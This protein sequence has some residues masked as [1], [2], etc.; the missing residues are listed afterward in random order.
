MIKGKDQK[1]Y[2]TKAEMLAANPVEEKVEEKTEPDNLK[3]F[4]K[5]MKDIETILKL[6][7]KGCTP[8]QIATKVWIAKAY[9]EEV[10]SK[11]YE[12]MESELRLQYHL[13]AEKK[14]DSVNTD[15]GEVPAPDEAEKAKK[16]KREVAAKGESREDAIVK[17][18]QDNPEGLTKEG[19]G[20]AVNKLLNINRHAW[21][22]TIGDVKKSGKITYDKEKKLYYAA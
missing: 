4:Q 13:P 14:V 15:A 7:E 3:P 2:K 9:V 8:D 19:I 12:Q 16:P 6:K 22:H 11:G 17:V 1:W 18:L 5:R 21:G 10:I 20:E